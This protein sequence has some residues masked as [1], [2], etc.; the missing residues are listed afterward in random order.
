MPRLLALAV[1]ASVLAASAGASDLWESLFD[2]RDDSAASG[3]NAFIAKVRSEAPKPGPRPHDDRYWVTVRVDGGPART[4]A[5]AMGLSIEMVEG[6][7]VS[8][9][10]DSGTLT[11]LLQAGL[12]IESRRPLTGFSAKDFPPADGIYHN[13]GEIVSELNGLA[14]AAEGFGAGFSIGTSVQGRAIPGI[15]LGYPA[16]DGKPKPAAAFLGTH[17]AREH[18]STEV[19]L[20]LARWLVEHAREPRVKKLL[21]TRDVYILPV[22]NPDGV[23][24]D[25][26][27]G[28]YKWQRKNMR[29]NGDGTTGVDLNRNYDFRFGGGGSSDYPGSDTYHGKSAF[30]EPESRAVR[31]FVEGLPALKMMVSFHTFSELV[32]YPWGGADEPISD[33]RALAAY[34]A[35]AGKVS[36][37]NGYRAMQS[38]ELYVATGDTCDWAWASKGVFCLTFELTPKSQWDGGFY[39]GAGAVAGTFQK[40]LEPALYLI[41]LAD[42]PYRAGNAAASAGGAAA[43]GSSGR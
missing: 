5:A 42:D 37:W 28:S 20:L 1:L 40:N 27:T 16:K 38:S 12:V 26:A 35:M 39:P 23:E 30:S 9:V 31:D 7:T 22:I 32:M 33:G 11:R 15:R 29:D 24:Y 4:R 6:G 13:Y 19:P 34:K 36:Q 14:Q 21:E 17:H 25:I 41:D 18:L 10:A 2:G 8:G 43:A 3:L